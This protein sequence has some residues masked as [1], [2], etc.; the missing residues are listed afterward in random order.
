MPTGARLAIASFTPIPPRSPQHFEA[1]QN[2]ASSHWRPQALARY[3]WPGNLRQLH[4]ALR[5]ACALLDDDEALIDWAHLPDDLAEGL[6]GSPA[7]NPPAP[8][9]LRTQAA[10]AVRQTLQ[11]CAGNHSEAA[12]QLGISRNTLYRK[13]RQD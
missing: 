13:L 6:R 8:A 5:T 11:A 12:R 3:R 7:T 1:G 10:Q 9:A 2:S 4:N